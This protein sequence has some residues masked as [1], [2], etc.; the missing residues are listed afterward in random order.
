[1]TTDS[2]TPAA[3]PADLEEETFVLNGLIT[4]DLPLLVDAPARTLKPGEKI[5]RHPRDK[6][7]VDWR[8]TGFHFGEENSIV[9]E[10][11]LPNDPADADPHTWTVT[12]PDAEAQ[13][14]KLDL[15]PV[16]K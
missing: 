8:V 7:K 6:A 13:W 16:A 14:L 1:M 11:R 15:G 10:Y 3:P 2:L 9:V 4:E 5:C 12:D